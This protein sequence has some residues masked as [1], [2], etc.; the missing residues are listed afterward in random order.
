MVTT[1]LFQVTIEAHEYKLATLLFKIEQKVMPALVENVVVDLAGK[2]VQ[3]LFASG[4]DRT[5]NLFVLACQVVH[6]K[7][8]LCHVNH[9]GSDTI[10]GL[11]L[12]LQLENAHTIVVPSGKVVEF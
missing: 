6:D 10:T 12:L 2:I 7:L 4:L 1:S 5:Q 8:F 9:E 11:A 3:N